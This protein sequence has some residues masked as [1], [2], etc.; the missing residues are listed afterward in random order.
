MEK[1]TIWNYVKKS[2]FLINKFLN[3]KNVFTVANFKNFTVEIHLSLIYENFC[4]IMN[5]LYK[6]LEKNKLIINIRQ[7][8]KLYDDEKDQIF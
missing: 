2:W 3:K 5:F 7:L 4:Q 8:I 6:E 1:F